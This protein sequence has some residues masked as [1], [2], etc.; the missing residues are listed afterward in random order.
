MTDSLLRELW[1]YSST[2]PLVFTGGVFYRYTE[3]EGWLQCEESDLSRI[4]SKTLG[5]QGLQITERRYRD[6]LRL[7]Q[8][9]LS[10][11]THAPGASL[12]SGSI[13]WEDEAGNKDIELKATP[14]PF[15]VPVRNGAV[16]IQTGEYFPDLRE[17]LFSIGRVPC[18]FDPM[19]Q[20]P[21]W[22]QFISE[23]VAPDDVKALQMLFGLSLTFERR[24]N[25]FFLFSGEGGTGK[26]TAMEIL[27]TVNQ[28][29]VC[30]ISISDMGERFLNYDLTTAR[31]NSVKDMDRVFETGNVSKR[32]AILKSVTCG[33]T[34]QVEK[35][36][37][38]PVTRKFTALCVFGCNSLPRFSDRSQAIFDRM[39]IIRFPHKFRG[40]DKQDAHLVNKLK[41]EL[42]GI[43]NWAI[44]GYQQL[45]DLQYF[46]ESPA[47][48][49]LKRDAIKASRPEELFFDDCLFAT[50]NPSDNVRTTEVYTA[51]KNWCVDN[52]YKPQASNSLI[53]LVP[54]YF[55]GKVTRGRGMEAGGRAKRFYGLQLVGSS[56]APSP[57]DL[58]KRVNWG[59]AYSPKRGDY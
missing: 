7:C 31:L 49:A 47:A 37:V 19:A 55:D 45:K 46:P 35:K 38:A 43:L 10:F 21:R 58:K 11:E 2:Q 29:S 20:C 32:E 23:S 48:V 24:F 17:T 33:E 26:S 27:E 12:L 28:G 25:V 53:P 16:N 34:A 18:V 59:T 30:S 36:H 51:Y 39:R 3:G 5:R 42:P 57:S 13:V 9:N 52:G 41:A 4:V 8:G 15:L 50:G 56:V 14:A 1:Q 40:T 22:L 44:A 6:H 54:S